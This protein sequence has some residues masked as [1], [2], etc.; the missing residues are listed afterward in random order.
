MESQLTRDMFADMD[1]KDQIH[2]LKP[3]ALGGSCDID[4]PDCEAWGF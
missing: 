3:E 1:L 2:K 4:Y